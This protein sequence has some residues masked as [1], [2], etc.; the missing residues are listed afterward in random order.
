MPLTSSMETLAASGAA[1]GEFAGARTAASF[2]SPTA[3]LGALL[4]GSAV[5]DLS[6]R[7]KLVVS[8]EDRVRW[9]NGMVTSNVR[10]L[11]VQHGNFAYILNPQG[12]IQA[13]AL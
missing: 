5:Y 9:M 6:W 13:D 1:F 2:G 7:G 3:E 11:Q 4:S 8:G 10:D 12:R